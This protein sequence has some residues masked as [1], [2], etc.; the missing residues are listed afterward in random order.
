LI[1]N[2]FLFQTKRDLIL[3]T[4]NI[5]ILV[6]DNFEVYINGELEDLPLWLNN[7]GKIA[8]ERRANSVYVSS[9]EGFSLECSSYQQQCKFHLDGWY[10]GKVAG[11]FGT[12]NN[13][14][15]DDLIGPD[16]SSIVSVEDF[17]SQWMVE[18]T[19]CELQTQD[20]VSEEESPS[21]ESMCEL[22]FS[23]QSSP[24]YPCFHVVD[25]KAF[26]DMCLTNARKGNT[27]GSVFAYLTK[28]TSS[29]VQLWMPEFCGESHLL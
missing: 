10:T 28:C 11:L 25:P 12:Y 22:F 7:G 1:T 16:W 9:S 5:E 29:G 3:T 18:A 26:Y 21:Y 6:K 15:L 27:C 14:P 8:L 19:P 4:Q 24:F 13:E 17:V 23:S 2:I 20:E